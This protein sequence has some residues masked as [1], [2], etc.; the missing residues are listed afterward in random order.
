MGVEIPL[1]YQA[2]K[3]L[4]LFAGFSYNDTEFDKYHDGQNDYSGKK[5]TF[6]PEYNYNLGVLYR[7]E[8]GYYASADISGYGDMYLSTNND[9]K[10]S[11]YEL[12]NAKIGYESEHLDIYFYVKNLFDRNY[13]I[14]GHYNGVYSYYS[15]PRELGVSATCRF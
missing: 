4:N 1:N 3:S 11:A 13:D 2:T 12:V 6:S 10:R 9:Q 5:T 7:S 15:P 8:G 14:D